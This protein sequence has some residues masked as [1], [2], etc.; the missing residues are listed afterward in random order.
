MEDKN[1]DVLAPVKIKLRLL[2]AKEISSAIIVLG[3][4]AC[5]CWMLATGRGN[6]VW[7]PILIGILAVAS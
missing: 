3:C 4:L 1:K 7:A 2:V 6:V 5:V